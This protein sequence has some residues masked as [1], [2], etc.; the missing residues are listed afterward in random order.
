M[1]RPTVLPDA[2]LKDP[3]SFRRW[4]SALLFALDG[5][6]NNGGGWPRQQAVDAPPQPDETVEDIQLEAAEGLLLQD[7]S[8]IHI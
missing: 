1:S 8:L 6:R 2:K 7:L 5:D 4:S 3:D